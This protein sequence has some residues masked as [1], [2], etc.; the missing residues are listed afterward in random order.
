[1]SKLAS[2]IVMLTLCVAVLAAAFMLHVPVEVMLTWGMG[3][4]ALCW[5]LVMVTLPWNVYFQ[6]RHVLDEIQTSRERGIFVPEDRDVMARKLAKRGLVTSVGLHVGSAA[7]MACVTVISGSTW[8]L[9]FAGFYLLSTFFRPGLEYY[10]FVHAKLDALLQQVSFP[11]EDIVRMQGRMD[12]FERDVED[13]RAMLREQRRIE[14]EL[15]R[16]LHLSVDNSTQRDLQ[17]DL[18]ITAIARKFEETVDKLT[19]NQD[20]IRGIKAFLR[21]MQENKHA[22]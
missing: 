1:M 16:D 15:R 20:V 10:R 9:Y 5:M 11:R 2:A 18:R 8:G 3:L 13:F 21:L 7:V 14:E 22:S 6:A 12:T 19:D 4:G 17:L